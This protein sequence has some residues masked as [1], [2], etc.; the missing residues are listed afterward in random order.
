MIV[1]E[2]KSYVETGNFTVPIY[3]AKLVF[4]EMESRGL[5]NITRKEKNELMKLYTEKVRNERRNTNA[6]ERALIPSDFESLVK[7]NCCY[8]CI[9]DAFEKMKNEKVKL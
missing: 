4:K 6:F 9:Q 1:E 5:I 3:S 7:L 8:H 2:Y